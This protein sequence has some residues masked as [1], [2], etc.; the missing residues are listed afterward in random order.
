MPAPDPA[1]AVVTGPRLFIAY[2]MSVRRIK[3][4]L[5]NV[6]DPEKRVRDMRAIVPGLAGAQGNIP[7]EHVLGPIREADGFVAVL[8]RPNAN[9]GFELGYA[10]AFD[11]PTWL[12]SFAKGREPFLE[13]VP[14]RT[15]LIP[16]FT[17]ASELREIVEAQD[18]LPKLASPPPRGPK[19]LLLCPTTGAGQDLR[20]RLR[21]DAPRWVPFDEDEW[22]L[23]DMPRLLDGVGTVV[24]AYVPPTPADVRDGDENAALAVLAGYAHG[25]GLGLKFWH[26]GV[27]GEDRLLADLSG[28]RRLLPD[29]KAVK[30]EVATVEAM[31]GKDEYTAAVEDYRKR[32]AEAFRTFRPLGFEGR[33]RVE[34]GFD[35][36]FFDM[37]CRHRAVGDRDLDGRGIPLAKAFD[38]IGKLAACRGVILLGE[39]GAG[40]TTQLRR[41]LRWV[42]SRQRTESGSALDG[43]L[44]IFVS[45]RDIDPKHAGDQL[46]AKA[47]VTRA[48]KA[49]G[50][51]PSSKDVDEIV[52]SENL[53]LLLDG[54]D[55]IRDPKQRVSAA[56]AVVALA[57]K[58]RVAATCRYAGYEAV[59]SSFE[60]GFLVLEVPALN[61]EQA[62]AFVVRWYE[63][64][65][66]AG[67]V[68]DRAKAV[69]GARD[70]A[71]RLNA[72]IAA[73]NRA[74]G[75]RDLTGNPL[76]LTAVCLVHRDVKRLPNG[77]AELYELCVRILL[78]Q[79]T[80]DKKSG[81]DMSTADA[82]SIL[83]QLALWLHQEQGRQSAT[84]EDLEPVLDQPLRRLRWDKGV[85]PFLEHIRDE[86]GLV[87]DA[88]GGGF[89]FLHLCFQEFLAAC[90]L[91]Q[92]AFDDRKAIPNL[93][94]RLHES[95]WQEVTAL[96]LAQKQSTPFRSYF[97][98]AAKLPAFGDAA[99]LTFLKD[100]VQD[101]TKPSPDPFLKTLQARP[102]TRRSEWPRQLAAL[103]LLKWRW[104]EE[105]RGLKER[106][107][108]KPHPYRAIQ[109]ALELPI[110]KTLTKRVARGAAKSQRLLVA[111]TPAVRT[112]PAEPL[113]LVLGR[114]RLELALIPCGTFMMGSREGE[115]GRRDSEG[116]QHSVTLTREFYIGRSPVT[117]EQYAEFLKSTDKPT[118]VSEPAY[119]RDKRFNS[120]LQP[121]VG[122]SW[123]DA[124]AF[125]DWAGRAAPTGFIGALP[126]EAQW[127]YACRAG[128]SS[129]YWSGDDPAALSAVGWFSGTSGGRPPEVR[130]KRPNGF[131]LYD[132]HGNVWE[133]CADGFSAYSADPQQDP[134]GN[135]R[136]AARVLRGGSWG[137]GAARC[138]SAARF[139]S[140]P[141]GRLVFIGFRFVLSLPRAR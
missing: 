45:L 133:W 26:Y 69:T 81:L 65:E 103:E 62:D 8:D 74:K 106:F 61:A 109:E 49:V 76:L 89:K 22:S 53:L 100:A 135:D 59:K 14:L 92:Q 17:S 102:S 20:E 35:E 29:F 140:L 104:P 56:K 52:R 125:C 90:E 19:L 7:D 123:H 67:E 21:G 105:L 12:A 44:P 39:P 116:P 27:L 2:D 64:V 75:L 46:T 60:D 134:K 42:A 128:T 73:G 47:L 48:I 15:Q 34:I 32:A 86:T 72:E 121:V 70:T 115:P 95:W 31:R 1:P 57:E 18:P 33:F 66:T 97:E 132:M 43:L 51:Q 4:L 79:W 10:L 71:A 54:L 107:A 130:E 23:S 24:W 3:D 25:R 87:T 55:E 117:N 77:R 13:K 41:L 126:T 68:P 94:A 129:A 36:L 80:R 91:H 127:E 111:E 16:P 138:R 40:K 108:K 58:H 101:A 141:D 82:Q 137:S 83:Q 99:N 11:K 85:A 6:A 50:I 120:S 124:K 131:G 98:A 78:E 5:S 96:L 114:A 38:R 30:K 93:A 119:W 113:T 110:Q 139:G 63:A 136:S 122:V 84:T 9:V 112:T 118:S 37:N 28:I 88:I